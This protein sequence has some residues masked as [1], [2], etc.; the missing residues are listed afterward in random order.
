MKAEQLHVITVRAN[1][2]RWTV[3]DRI[4]HDWAAHILASG[5]ALTVVECQ[6]GDRPFTCQIPGINHVGVRARTLTWVK[7][8]CLNIGL[9]SLPQDWKYVAWIDSDIFFRRPD[10][11]SETVEALQHFDVIQ[12]WSDCYDLGPNGEHMFLHR[13][14]CRLWMDNEPIMQ[15]PRAHRSPYRFAH[16]GYAWA[17]TRG[18]LDRLGGLID[19]AILG[20][21]DHHMALALIDRVRES[22]PGT[23]TEG[24]KRPL[25]RWQ[26]RA[27]HHIAGN[28]G[29]LSGTIEHRFHGSK[30]DR[31]YQSRWDIL[32]R[33]HFDP[34]TDL[35]R[36][37]W[38][39]WDLAG[40]KPRLRR[41]IERYFRT[42]NEDANVC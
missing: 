22:Y 13:S 7:E 14:F 24:Y 20:S 18:A 35:I 32:T 19:T 4:Y 33:N 8:R 29:A 5:A 27:R 34:E 40:N 31:A 36:N 3:P 12:P 21:A 28:I 6:Y 15:G 38:A 41:E 11:A 37:I 39:V 2:L 17:A 1:P 23:V 10:W 42:R 16:P 30:R 25:L 9:A 26:E